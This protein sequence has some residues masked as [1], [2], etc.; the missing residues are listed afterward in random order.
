MILVD[1]P[2]PDAILG[3]NGKL[4]RVREL[5]KARPIPDVQTMKTSPPR[6]LSEEDQKKALDSRKPK[7]NPP[8]DRLPNDIQQLQLWAWS[9]PPRT[10]QGEDHLPEEMNELYQHSLATAHPLGDRPLISILGM[11]PDAAPP[12]IS[13]ERW[14]ALFHEKIDQKRGYRNLS[15]NSKVVEDQI[16]GHNVPLDDP[17]TV[18][19]AIREVLNAAQRHTPLLP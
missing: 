7:I 10:A 14:D 6:L 9:L 1:A 19:T 3:Y 12:D 5:A 11:R 2:S 13:Q 16:A 8:Y 4:V 15:T 18:V 17:D